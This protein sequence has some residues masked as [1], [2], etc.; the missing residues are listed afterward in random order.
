ITGIYGMLI[1]MTMILVGLAGDLFGQRKVFYYGFVL[2]GIAAIGAGAA[3][4]IGW[5]I[6]FRGLQGV[7]GSMIF[8]PSVA[9]LPHIFPEHEQGIAIGV[10][11]AITGF[12]LAVGPFLGGLLITLLSWR[13]VFWINIPI[14]AAGFMLC[15]FNLKETPKPAQKPRIDWA[16][17]F[18]LTIGIGCLIYGIIHGGQ[19]GW[20]LQATWLNLLIGIAALIALVIVENKVANPLLELHLF[21]NKNVALATLIAIAAGIILFVFFAFFDALYLRIIL[22]QSAMMIGLTLLT[23]PLM[24]VL[25]SIVLPKLLKAFGITQFIVA[26]LIIAFIAVVLHIFIP[27]IPAIGYLLLALVFTGMAWGMGGSGSIYAINQSVPR[28]KIGS[29]TGTVFTLWNMAGPIC[30]AIGSVIFQYA[31]KSKMSTI[32]T[33]NNIALTPEQQQ[34]VAASLADPDQAS[35][36]LTQ[37]AGSNSDSILSAFKTSFLAGY[38]AVSVVIVLIVL[39][40]LALGIRAARKKQL[41]ITD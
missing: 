23:V 34:A 13:W 1:S 18:L 16:G 10:F 29:V 12:G 21:K 30:L 9:L 36:M 5:L 41:T 2:F 24:Q 31:E 15:V 19:F 8:I 17:F 39:V 7:S 6:F 14:I 28:D 38:Q 40:L 33:A 22:N 11:T 4:S 35:Q 20:Q 26:G 25:L 32:L 3:P 37:I 27:N